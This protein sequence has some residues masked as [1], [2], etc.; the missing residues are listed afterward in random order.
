[1]RANQLSRAN[2]SIG[3]MLKIPQKKKDLQ[4]RV[5]GTYTVQP[6]D[7]PYEI[8]KKHNMELERFLRLNR[9]APRS[10]IFPGQQMRVEE[11]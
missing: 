9:L 11:H 5:F 4:A 6:G 10:R 7:S 8:A 1:M 3:Q 2:L